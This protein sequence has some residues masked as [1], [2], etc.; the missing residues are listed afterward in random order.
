MG[1]E[2]LDMMP[3]NILVSNGPINVSNIEKKSSLFCKGGWEPKHPAR[4]MLRDFRAI[5]SVHASH[6]SRFQCS[7]VCSWLQLVFRV[8]RILI[9]GCRLHNVPYD[10]ILDNGL[11]D[12]PPSIGLHVLHISRPSTCTSRPLQSFQPQWHIDVHL[13]IVCDIW[14]RMWV[15]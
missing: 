12:C 14:A 13:C 4:L 8:I 9:L 15:L 10:F 3:S 7:R 5:T 1:G 11:H 2:S 6:V